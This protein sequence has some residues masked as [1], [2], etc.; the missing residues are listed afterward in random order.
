MPALGEHRWPCSQCG[1]QLRYAP[2]QRDLVCEHCGNHQRLPDIALADQDRALVEH[3]LA[4]GLADDLSSSAMEVVRTT[5]CT[6]CGALIE[7]IGASHATECPFCA[8]P[9]VTS[10]GETRQI[11]PQALIP[12]VLSEREAREALVKWLGSLWFAPNRLLEYTRRGRAMNGVYVPW[13]TFD[14]ET[15]SRYSGSRGDA[16]YVSRTVTVNGKRE[17]RQERKIRWTPVSGHV[18][19]DFDDVGV[20]ASLSVPA[21][22]A[23]ELDPWDLTRLVPYAPDYLA[24]FSAEGYTVPLE[25]ASLQSKQKMARVIETDVRRDIGGDE[26]RISGIDTDYSGETFKHIMLPIWMA[27]Y[28]YNGKSYQFLVNG[29]TGEVQGQRPWSV[30]KIALAAVAA[31]LVAGAVLYLMKDGDISIGSN[32]LDWLD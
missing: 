9:V 11:K 25:P 22:Y 7:M 6:S 5:R 20:L 24:G 26:Q 27:A 18:A 4:K 1:A 14:A 2:G 13:W 32:A 28:K 8:T 16:Y 23:N 10:T 12:F 19:R 15:R 21:R 17:T 29:Q 3:D 30:W 31:A